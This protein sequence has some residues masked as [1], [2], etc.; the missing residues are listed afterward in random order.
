MNE[1]TVLLV[2]INIA[3]IYKS[4]QSIHNLK[5]EFNRFIKHQDAT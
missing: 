5:N 4:F 2:S 1:L 3:I